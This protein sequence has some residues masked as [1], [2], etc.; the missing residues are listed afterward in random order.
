MVSPPAIDLND[1][2][3]TLIGSFC[4]HVAKEMLLPRTGPIIVACQL[5]EANRQQNVQVVILALS[6]MQADLEHR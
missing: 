3:S 5:C 4:R 6:W 1:E 2:E